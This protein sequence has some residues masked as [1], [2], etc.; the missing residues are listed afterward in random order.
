MRNDADDSA[1]GGI[2]TGNGLTIG[3]STGILNSSTTFNVLATRGGCSPVE[4]DTK[5]TVNVLPSSDPSCGGGGGTGQCATV[6]VSFPKEDQTPATCTNS[7]GEVVFN[8]DPFVPAVN[9][10]GVIINIDG[11]VTRTIVNDSVFSN[12]PIGVYSYTIQYGDPSCIIPGNFTVD[13]SGTIG[14][15]VASN[16]VGPE[17]FG[18]NGVLNLDVPGETGN[19][20]QWSLDGVIWNS[21]VAGSQIS[22]P[23]G[24][25]PSFEQVI[26]VRRDNTDPCNAAVTVVM[27]SQFNDIQLSASTTEASCDNNDGSIRV[28]SVSGG[29]GNYDFR[30]DGIFHDELP[31]NNTFE[32]L[33]GDNHVLTVIDAGAGGCEKD[34]NIIVP[35]PGLVNFTTNVK[36]PDCTN[37]SASNGE[38]ELNISSIGQFQ[39][40]I[41]TD[42]ATDPTEFFNVASNG[43]GSFTFSELTKGDYYVT[44]VSTGATC[45]NRRK[46]TIAAGPTAVSFD[47]ELGCITGGQNKELLLTN[48]T[49]DNTA[50]YTLRVFDKFT[51]DMVDEITFTLNSGQQF[52]VQNRTFLNFNKEYNLRLLQEQAACPGTEIVF[53]HP[54]GLVVPTALYAEA[55]ET[56]SSLP[57]RFTGTMKIHKFSG[58]QPAYLTRIELDSAAVPGQSYITDYDTVR[59]NSNFE[60]EM[61]YKD[62]PAGRY[63]VEIMDEFGCVIERVAR[64]ELN[65]SVFIPNVFT[66]NNDGHNDF[67]FVRNLPEFGAE[68]VITNRWGTVVYKKKDYQNNWTAEGVP[69]GIYFYKLDVAGEIYNGWVEILRGQP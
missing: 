22:I 19:N 28:T 40:G 4:M 14:T 9:N 64:V 56:T 67:F 26:A 7:D 55:G 20:L 43:S 25:A 46:V 61:V 17:C 8:I 57:D 11:P 21:F 38:I 49:G 63:L 15:P 65:T 59:V 47:Y 16:I 42:Q 34:F 51:T 13:Q 30:L 60:Y 69:D 12:L 31:T 62:I 39:V 44:V 48:I 23:V 1:I 58:G 37:N 66:P 10:T 24:P 52:L 35:Y 36:D 18:G 2:V 32:N 29:S 68:L 50:Q 45:P 53:N 3:L 41:S 33:A 6:V 27:Q 54:K 5:V